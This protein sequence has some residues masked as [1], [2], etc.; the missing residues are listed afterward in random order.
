MVARFNKGTSG[1]TKKGQKAR[2]NKKHFVAEKK[3]GSKAK[4]APKPVPVA[5]EAAKAPAKS[6]AATAT[7]E[8]QGK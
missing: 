2:R 7:V 3:A 8:T 1:Q 6:T 4:H 5:G